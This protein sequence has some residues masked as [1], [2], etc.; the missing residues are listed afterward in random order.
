MRQSAEAPLVSSLTRPPWSHQVR[1]PG[2]PRCYAYTQTPAARRSPAIPRPLR[3]PPFFHN[4]KRKRREPCSSTHKPSR[5]HLEEGNRDPTAYLLQV[6]GLAES[7]GNGPVGNQ[8]PG[9]QRRSFA[10]YGPVGNTVR[11]EHGSHRTN[12]P[13]RKHQSGAAPRSRW[14]RPPWRVLWPS[15]YSCWS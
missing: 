7:T 2:M 4:R 5:E 14:P 10:D 3:Q 15:S 1:V 9:W 11:Q 12:W 8:Y 6:T 13:S